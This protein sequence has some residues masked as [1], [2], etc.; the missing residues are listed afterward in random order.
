MVVFPE[1]ADQFNV[2]FNQITCMYVPPKK[3]VDKKKLYME[4][5]VFYLNHN[6]LVLL[7]CLTCFFQCESTFP[8]TKTSPDEKVFTDVCMPRTACFFFFLFFFYLCIIFWG[9]MYF[10]LSF[11]YMCIQKCHHCQQSATIFLCILVTR[12]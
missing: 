7:N 1:Q 3:K 11:T 10:S 8:R 12:D 5:M 4:I 2:F 9:V 6:M